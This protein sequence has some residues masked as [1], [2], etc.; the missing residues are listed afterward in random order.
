MDS[1]INVHVF[2]IL[3]HFTN[4]SIFRY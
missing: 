3:E 1:D 4:A 2:N